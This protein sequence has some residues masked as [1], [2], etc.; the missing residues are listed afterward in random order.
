MHPD[1]IPTCFA[2]HLGV[3]MMEPKYL[4]QAVA[5]IQQG[6]YPSKAEVVQTAGGGYYNK[7]EG[8]VAIVRINGSITKGQSK[9]GG[10]S[11]VAVRQA[12]RSARADADVGGILLAIDSPGGQVAGTAELA[13]EI[14][15]TAEEMPLHAHIED[16][17]ASAAYWA[18]AG[19]NRITSNRM[20]EIGSIGVYGVVVDTSG[21][22]EREG[23]KVHVISTGDY[24]CPRDRDHRGPARRDAGPN[25]CHAWTLFVSRDRWPWPNWR[26]ARSSQRRS[27]LPGPN[28]TRNGPD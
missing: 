24:R 5:L 6:L 19:A 27:C 3:W 18:A 8:G 15:A 4:Q 16:L 13:D 23:V 1:D 28:R 10:T 21:A 17:G 22:M 2:S 14:A 7:T 9:F 26:T 11:S 25:R 12:I 20:A